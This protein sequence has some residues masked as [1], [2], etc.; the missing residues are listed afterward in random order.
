[1]GQWLPEAGGKGGS[2]KGEPGSVASKFQ[3]GQ[4]PNSVLLHSV[5]TVA[6][7]YISLLHNNIIFQYN[8]RGSN[9]LSTKF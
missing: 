3:L 2:R 4:K 9:G 1:M 8:K 7:N 6:D 5:V